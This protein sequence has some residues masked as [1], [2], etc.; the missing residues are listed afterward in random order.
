MGKPTGYGAMNGKAKNVNT[1][2]EAFESIDFERF[3]YSDIG[4]CINLL[5]INIQDKKKIESFLYV[6]GNKK[7]KSWRIVHDNSENNCADIVFDFE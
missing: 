6:F 1:V 4:V 7:I 2:R 3:S 5:S